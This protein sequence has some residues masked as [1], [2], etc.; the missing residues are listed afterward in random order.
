MKIFNCKIQC[1][2][3]RFLSLYSL[4][5]NNAIKSSH[6]YF[7]TL[8]RTIERYYVL[9]LNIVS[10]GERSISLCCLCSLLTS[11]KRITF[12]LTNIA[13]SRIYKHG[14]VACVVLWKKV[15]NYDKWIMF[16]IIII[17]NNPFYEIF[18]W[19]AF[20]LCSYLYVS[21]KLSFISAFIVDQ[22]LLARC[23]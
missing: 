1:L 3:Q 21:L 20:L 2:L 12:F 16:F 23:K 6:Y 13:V 19:S 10:L 9:F 5:S 15:Y 14:R 11:W 18:L 4:L 7:F 22:K 17:S 8:Y